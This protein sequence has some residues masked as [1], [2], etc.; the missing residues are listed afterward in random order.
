MEELVPLIS[1]VVEAGGEALG[2]GEV[3]EVKDK[4]GEGVRDRVTLP[5][6]VALG[7]ALMLRRE[8]G[9][10]MEVSVG[11]RGVEDPKA[12]DGESEGD[13]EVE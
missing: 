7:Y 11:N 8:V 6:E 12:A 13:R 5:Q 9:L 2:E 3:A 1:G 10:G 4:G